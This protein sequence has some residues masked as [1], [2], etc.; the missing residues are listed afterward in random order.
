MSQKLTENLKLCQKSKFF[1]FAISNSWKLFI[2]KYYWL[3]K[4][5]KKPFFFLFELLCTFF[6][7]WNFL[8]IRLTVYILLNF[9][10]V[11][12]LFV[13]KI[14]EFLIQKEL[15]AFYKINDLPSMIFFL[16][17]FFNFTVIS[18]IFCLL[19]LLLWFIFFYNFKRISL[20]LFGIFIQFWSSKDKHVIHVFH[21]C[22]FFK[23]M[24]S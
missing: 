2:F 19:F 1:T 3:F 15:I 10:D 23:K 11:T 13:F 12:F 9:W 6:F 8:Q 24:N 16:Q 14:K 20:F 17:L 4:T 18:L 5:K 7:R 21:S 22:L